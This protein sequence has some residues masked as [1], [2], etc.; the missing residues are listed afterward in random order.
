MKK[1]LRKYLKRYDNKNKKKKIWINNLKKKW[2]FYRNKYICVNQRKKKHKK[3][4]EKK[5][6]KQIYPI[7]K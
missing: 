5:N 2:K 1:I 3:N 4:I 6:Q 7:I